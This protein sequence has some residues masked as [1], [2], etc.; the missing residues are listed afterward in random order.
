VV[1]SVVVVGAAVVVVSTVVVATA[2]D[3]V[4]LA[5]GAAVSAFAG[6]FPQATIVRLIATAA[7]I[8]NKFPM[9]I[10]SIVF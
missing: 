8:F 1:A 6:A 9:I 7:I 2:S 3:I 10:T 4:T 5:S